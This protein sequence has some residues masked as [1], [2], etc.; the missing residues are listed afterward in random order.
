[1]SV[2]AI[3]IEAQSAEK[4]STPHLSIMS[5]NEAKEAP[6]ERGRVKIKGKISEGMPSISKS[7]AVYSINISV[8]PDAKSILT[9]TI[10]AHIEGISPNADFAPFFA[11]L[12]KQE[13]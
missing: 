7:G 11:P 2:E 5:V 3:I 1:M 12:K 9:P 6:K 10:K 13:K 4:E 8:A